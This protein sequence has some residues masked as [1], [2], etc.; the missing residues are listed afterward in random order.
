MLLIMID[1]SNKRLIRLCLA[2]SH[3]TVSLV[4]HNHVGIHKKPEF[5]GLAST[6]TL[7]HQGCKGIQSGNLNLE[8]CVMS[9]F[10]THQPVPK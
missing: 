2:G 7:S 4:P 10:L 1:A 6:D 5:E 3:Q 8:D 9:L